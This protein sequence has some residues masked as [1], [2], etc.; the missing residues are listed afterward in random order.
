MNCT[1]VQEWLELNIGTEPAPEIKG[2]LVTCKE[3]AAVKAELDQIT[4]MLD[5]P[6]DRFPS[7]LD[8]AQL[9]ENTIANLEQKTPIT[10]LV[11]WRKAIMRFAAAAAIAL[12]AVGSY[13]LSNNQ[14][15]SEPP[16]VSDLEYEDIQVVLPE[17]ELQPDDASIESLYS[18]LLNVESSMASDVLLD[19]LS[20][21]ELDYLEKNFDVGELLL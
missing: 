18:G 2:H 12:V 7:D 17:S 16:P 3:C 19:D 6:T 10:S 21:D 20:A 9:A 8:A 15:I 13:W 1:H 4:G 5:V 14:T 11:S